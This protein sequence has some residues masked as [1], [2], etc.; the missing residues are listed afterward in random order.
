M[1]L[2]AGFHDDKFS[3][4]RLDKF[5]RKVWRPFADLVSRLQCAPSSYLWKWSFCPST[6]RKYMRHVYDIVGSMTH[7]RVK[8][9]VFDALPEDDVLGEYVLN[10]SQSRS[11]YRVTRRV[12]GT[13]F[14]RFNSH[15]TPWWEI[16]TRDESSAFWNIHRII[17]TAVQGQSRA[18]F[19]DTDPG[20]ARNASILWHQIHW[21]Q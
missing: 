3:R 7:S 8:M 15:Q 13:D 5:L 16:T 19:I 6:V 4:N 12:P 10:H 17:T 20:P 11:E 21:K 2:E 9:D 18:P 1:L 14:E